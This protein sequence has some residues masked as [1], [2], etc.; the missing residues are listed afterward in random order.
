M[1]VNVRKYVRM[2]VGDYK[3][4]LDMSAFIFNIHFTRGF[5]LTFTRHLFSHENCENKDI[6]SIAS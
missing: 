3:S 6:Y 1:C 4:R 5:L 2:C